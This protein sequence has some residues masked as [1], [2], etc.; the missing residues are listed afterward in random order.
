[1]STLLKVFCSIS[2]AGLL[3]IAVYRFVT[4]E[5][6]R[7]G[8]FILQLAVLAVCFG[9]LYTFFFTREQIIVKGPGHE[10]YFV[11]VL[12]LCMLLGMLAQYLHKR[13]EQP[14]ADRKK[15]KFDFGM[16]IAPVFASPIVFIPLLAAL[17]NVVTGDLRN[18]TTAKLMVFFVAFEN[19]FFWKE[20]FDHRRKIKQED[21]TK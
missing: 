3:I 15:Q 13:F 5:T 16:F 6:K 1:M 9:V 8:Y 7:I 18:L 12:Y 4:A 14:K 10:V 21:A 19:G 11:L 20:Y 2:L 17:Q